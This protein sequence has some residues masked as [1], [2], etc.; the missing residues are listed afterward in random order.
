[1]IRFLTIR[2]V[3]DTG[4]L[5]EWALRRRLR[6][7]KLPGVYSASRFYVDAEELERMLKAESLANAQGVTA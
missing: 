1:M 5:P 2:E 4:I 3:A 6:E 7:G